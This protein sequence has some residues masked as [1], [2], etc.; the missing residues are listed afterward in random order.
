MKG[1]S[2]AL[3]W[4]WLVA[5]KPRPGSSCQAHE[6][7]CLDAKRALVCDDGRLV[8]TPCRGKSGCS[9]AQERV[10]CDISANLP[11][12]ACSKA[13][14]GAAVCLADGAML[15]CHARKYE[16][17]ACRGPRGCEML[18]AQANCDQSIAEPGEVCNKAAAKACSR[19]GSQV[20]SCEG[21][22]LSPLY[23]CR[24]EAGCRAAAGKLSCDQTL[25]RL[26]DNCDKALGG[27]TA[28]AEDRKSLLVC[29]G[30]RFAL[31]EHC[32]AGKS[33]K[34]DGQSTQCERP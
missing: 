6:A 4:L 11:G 9:T 17:V 20:L 15:A 32:K 14:E 8:E 27:S 5:C 1:V 28:C 23:L 29:Q 30:E 18:G 25:A 16:R 12:D 26:G 19:D 22:R 21:G 10:A 7:H 24:G 3:L 31:S 2:L 13:E 33:C 34:V